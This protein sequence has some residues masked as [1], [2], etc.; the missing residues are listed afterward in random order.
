[1]NLINFNC[2]L[3]EANVSAPVSPMPAI[4]FYALLFV[5]FWFLF[6]APQRRKQKQHTQMLS[7]LGN[8][9]EIL[10]SSGIYGK[11]VQDSGEKLIVKIAEN[12]KIE[13]NRTFVQS[14]VS[15]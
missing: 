8:G 6:V 10:M 14:R 13:V 5:G 11:I 7:E 4:L 9:D 1:M 3:A 15:S 2:I 12:T